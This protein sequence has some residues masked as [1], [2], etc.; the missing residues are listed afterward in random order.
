LRVAIDAL[1]AIS[2]GAV[3]HL[4]N[5]VSSLAA[6]DRS[7]DYWIVIQKNRAALL[8]ALPDNYR[9]R[10][11][12]SF[13]Q[14]YSLRLFYANFVLPTFLAR[15]K[16][17]VLLS[18][19][20][21]TTFSPPCPRVTVLH[22]VAPFHTGGNVRGS[23]LHPRMLLLRWGTRICLSN[24]DAVVFL[25]NASE[26]DVSNQLRKGIPV[27]KVVYHGRPEEFHNWPED[28]AAELLAR[29]YG[30]SYGDYVLCV[31]HFYA[32]KNFETLVEAYRM[33]VR[34]TSE[35][36]AL[37]I[38]GRPGDHTYYEK[39]LKMTQGHSC[40]ERI[41]ILQAVKDEDLP[42]LY[43]G[44]LFFVFPSLCENMPVTLL[45][46]MGCGAAMLVSD[47]S[48]MS[49]ICCEAASYFAPSSAQEL[50][51]KMRLLATDSAL[52]AHFRA[53]AVDRS[54]IFTWEKTARDTL[55]LLE[56]V[57]GC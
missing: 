23:L 14:H 6:I 30:L 28:R 49:E 57:V 51:D 42:A 35:R 52:R 13:C 27:S 20:N 17:D 43:S 9:L 40:G 2:G 48:A 19:A 38:A 12:P 21:V 41:K 31:S 18:L 3:S 56:Q 8:P 4:K 45:E 53:R 7:N 46:A 54:K 39:I 26:R 47:T 16:I 11:V 34:S 44:C 5:L 15:E 36:C 22:N 25:S 33:F 37:V 32:Y 24:S 10:L 50:A 55:G 1:S 29:S